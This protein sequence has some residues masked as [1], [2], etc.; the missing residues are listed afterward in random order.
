MIVTL[1]PTGMSNC[2]LSPAPLPVIA[3]ALSVVA[4]PASAVPVMLVMR[5]SAGI[6]SVTSASNAVLEF[7]PP[8]F[9]IVSV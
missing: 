3:T 1:A 7:A 6:V 8:G 2:P 5:M 9:V 4:P